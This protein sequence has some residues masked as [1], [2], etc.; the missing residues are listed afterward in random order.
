[1]HGTLDAS[2]SALEDSAGNIKG[3]GQAEGASART[4]TFLLNN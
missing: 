1:M 4:P 3:C 2:S